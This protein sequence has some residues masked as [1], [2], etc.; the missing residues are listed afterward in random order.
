MGIFAREV[1]PSDL[2]AADR[3]ERV[4]SDIEGSIGTQRWHDAK[5]ATVKLKYLEGIQEAARKKTEL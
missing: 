3:I 2:G 1:G 5:A 4:L